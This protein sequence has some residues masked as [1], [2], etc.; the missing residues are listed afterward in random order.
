MHLEN[1]CALMIDITQC[2]GCCSSNWEE[3]DGVSAIGTFGARTD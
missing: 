3:L 1:R 2:T